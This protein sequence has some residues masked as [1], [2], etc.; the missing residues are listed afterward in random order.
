MDQAK[1]SERRATKGHRFSVG[2]TSQL[3]LPPNGRRVGLLFTGP[4]GGRVSISFGEDAVDESTVILPVN[5]GPLYMSLK[6]YGTDIQKSV[7]GISSGIIV[8]AVFEVSRL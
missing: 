2:G 1:A 3:L 8:I 4:T 5:G 6:R 7:F